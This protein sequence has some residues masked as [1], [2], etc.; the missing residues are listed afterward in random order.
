MLSLGGPN[1]DNNLRAESRFRTKASKVKNAFTR[2]LQISDDH[3]L[4][5]F[6]NFL[7][8]EYFEKSSLSSQQTFP[9]LIVKFLGILSGYD[10][11]EAQN[12][13][14]EFMNYLAANSKYERLVAKL[15]KEICFLDREPFR[16]ILAKYNIL[17]D[18][19]SKSIRHAEFAA[20]KI[21]EVVGMKVPTYPDLEW[22]CIKEVFA[23]PGATGDA[24]DLITALHSHWENLA[25]K[26]FAVNFFDLELDPELTLGDNKGSFKI[27]IL[28][29]KESQPEIQIKYT[30]KTTEE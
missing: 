13:L 24:M 25:K 19:S 27:T 28:K 14:V 6:Y 29:A 5:L 23:Q 30:D 9:S 2:V 8:S 18:F 11:K 21:F 1:N 12:T 15:A 4:E 16:D 20:S 26:Y 3:L 7:G 10:S 17:K 22:L